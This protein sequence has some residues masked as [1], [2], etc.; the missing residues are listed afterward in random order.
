MYD[1]V[2]EEEGILSERELNNRIQTKKMKLMKW[3]N[4]TMSYTLFSLWN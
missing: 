2:D 1:R 3:S 4:L